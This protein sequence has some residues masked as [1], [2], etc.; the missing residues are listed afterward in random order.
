MI[1]KKLSANNFMKKADFLVEREELEDEDLDVIVSEIN[2]QEG[3]F[4]DKNN[5]KQ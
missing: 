5:S 1:G 4:K 2:K 3:E